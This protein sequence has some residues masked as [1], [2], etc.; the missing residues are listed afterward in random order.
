MAYR[1]AGIDVHK[2]V[3]AVVVADVEFDDGE[4]PFTRRQFGATP[5]ELRRLT[6]WL[7]ELEVEEVVMESTAQYWRP[8]WAALERDW[9][10]V[11]RRRVDA[12]PRTSSPSASSRMARNGSGVR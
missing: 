4:W 5:S 12:S 11:Q 7:I 10:S 3:L 2:K 9:Q 8:V 6:A 1:I